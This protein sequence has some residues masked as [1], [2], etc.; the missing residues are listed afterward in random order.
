MKTVIKFFA[1]T[2]AFAM[3]LSLAACAKPGD[4][5]VLT[6]PPEANSPGA[7]EATE[8]PAPTDEPAPTE[9][10]GPEP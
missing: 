9:P 7:P 1:L 10:A 5:P 4:E 3:L 2:L 6:T 8:A